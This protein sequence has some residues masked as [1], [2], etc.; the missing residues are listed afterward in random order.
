MILSSKELSLLFL[1]SF[2]LVSALTPLMRFV[3]L[4]FNVLDLPSEIHKTHSKPVPYLGG[5]AI[6][7]GVCIVT[8]IS[9]R[10]SNYSSETISLAFTVL[11]PA[12]IMSLVGLID[13]VRKLS[14][15]PRFLVQTIV[16]LVSSIILISTD[17]VGSPTSYRVLDVLL[18]VTWIVGLTNAINFFDNLDGGASGTVAISSFFIFLLAYINGQILI[19][20][21]SLVLSGCTLGFLTWNQPPARIY[22]G[23]AG[24]L[25]LGILLASLTIRLDPTPINEWARFAV[26]FSL[27]AVPIL[28]TSVAVISR[29]RRKVS[30]FKGGKDHLSHRLIR[31]GLTKK[32]AICIL[33]IMTLFFAAISVVISLAP[34]K[35]EG[36]VSFLSI[37]VWFACFAYFMGVADE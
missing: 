24:A 7:I 9:S 15:W 32:Q 34:F 4:K 3:A 23:D 2:I 33:W 27:V 29:L 8:Y 10:I 1:V 17:T 31:Q 36:F 14:P 6:V 22:M 20:A 30:P 12:L 21:I 35:F 37:C 19:A 13:D 11:I 28:D 16:G 25:F 26:L 18:S 5:I